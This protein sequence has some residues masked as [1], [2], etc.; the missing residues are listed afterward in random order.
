MTKIRPFNSKLPFGKVV[1][2]T[3]NGARYQ[4]GGI[5]YDNLRKPCKEQ[6]QGIEP[7]NPDVAT[8][9]ALK[10][11]GVDNETL[12]E[13]MVQERVNKALE[14]AGLPVDSENP[15]VPQTEE[16]R[17]EAEVQKRIDAMS[18][19]TG[20]TSGPDEDAEEKSVRELT[21]DE[22]HE[23]AS[24]DAAAEELA[25]NKRI[26]AAE[27]KPLGKVTPST[28]GTILSKDMDG[29]QLKAAVEQND[30]VYTNRKAALKFLS[31]E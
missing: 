12:I 5:D 28:T 30:G 27:P 6:S 29:A 11:L 22:V 1:G 31:G 26:L 14:A 10:S 8:A 2:E 15:L 21:E 23:K 25:E 24:K 4:Q 17:I 3:E 13:S 18:S 20:L 16:E 7:F 19:E 9:L